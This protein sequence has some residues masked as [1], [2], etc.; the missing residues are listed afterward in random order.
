MFLDLAK[1]FDS[2]D[3]SI[4]IR[5]LQKYGI[6]GNALELMKSY[7]QNRYHFVNIGNVNSVP[8]ILKYGVPQGS[9]L[10]PFLFLLFV[11]DLPN[12]TKFDV[13]LFAD[14]TFLK[15]QSHNLTDLKKQANKEMNK[16]GDWLISNNL[17][18][19]VGKSKYM[20][21]H[22]K[23]NKVTQIKTRKMSRI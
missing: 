22:R 12:C 8:L 6:R 18:L 4:L 15:L 5:K 19:N 1:A 14:D 11:N 23:K 20:I 17:T 2:V 9:V 10:G 16:V 21:I 13:T 3:H 7:L